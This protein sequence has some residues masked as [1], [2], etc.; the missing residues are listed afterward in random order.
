[1]AFNTNF[2]SQDCFLNTREYD[3]TDGSSELRPFFE[4]LDMIDWNRNYQTKNRNS[5]QE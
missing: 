1:M 4:K 3:G 2:G 5:I